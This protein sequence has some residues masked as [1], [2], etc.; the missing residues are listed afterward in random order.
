MGPSDQEN[1]PSAG[2]WQRRVSPQSE[3]AKKAPVGGL[4]LASTEIEINAGRPTVTLRVRNTG[5]RPI[6]VGSHYH[7]LEV[8]ALWNLIAVQPS[9]CVWIFRRRRPSGLNQGTRRK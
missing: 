1:E 2:D 5:D 9:V 6:Q 3:D 8:N 7:F 4:V